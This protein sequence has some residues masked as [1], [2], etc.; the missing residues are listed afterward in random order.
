MEAVS[1][2]VTIDS[3]LGDPAPGKPFGPLPDLF[4]ASFELF[5]ALPVLFSALVGE[6]TGFLLCLIQTGLDKTACARLD[7][8]GALA[9][10]CD[11]LPDQVRGLFLCLLRVG[12][13]GVL[14][15]ELNGR[16]GKSHA[17]E[18]QDGLFQNGHGSSFLSVVR[19]VFKVQ[20]TRSQ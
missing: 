8:S 12:R 17:E 2:L 1:R 16:D 4:R 20:I 7:L 9:E 19:T 18:S 11:A 3:T 5:R 6:L 13:R 14:G 15:R 10:R